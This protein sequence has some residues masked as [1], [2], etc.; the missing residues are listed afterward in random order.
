MSRRS[1]VSE[2]PN[3]ERRTGPEESLSKETPECRTSWS[4]KPPTFGAAI[5][6]QVSA[7]ALIEAAGSSC[8]QP[9]VAG[10]RSQRTV[11]THE[12][13]GPAASAMT[14]ESAAARNIL[15]L[16]LLEQE[17]L[18]RLALSCPGEATFAPLFSTGR[19]VW[20]AES[21]PASAENLAHYRRRHAGLGPVEDS[22]KSTCASRAV[23]KKCPLTRDSTPCY[24]EKK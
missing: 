4:T 14:R 17:P 8:W 18:Q 10:V 2:S 9:L 5:S 13:F 6:Q 1:W 15:T 11:Q 16:T 12:T 23:A 7:A 19:R 21:S 3:G 24:W 22:G 20:G